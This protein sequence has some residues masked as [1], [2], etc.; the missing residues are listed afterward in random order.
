MFSLFHFTWIFHR[1]SYLSNEMI[2]AVQIQLKRSLKTV[3][4]LL[5]IRPIPLVNLSQI[6]MNLTERQILMSLMEYRIL[7]LMEAETTQNQVHRS[8]AHSVEQ[9]QIQVHLAEMIQILVSR[10]VHR[11]LVLMVAVTIRQNHHHQSYSMKALVRQNLH[12]NYLIVVQFSSNH[13]CTHYF[14]IS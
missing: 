13:K 4:C 10:A 14:R 12:S 6:L 1:N 2:Q 11:I 8:Q 9:E 3:N 7:V 5:D